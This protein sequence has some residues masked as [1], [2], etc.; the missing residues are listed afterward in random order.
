MW[1]ITYSMIPNFYEKNSSV[2]F[3]LIFMKIYS[4]MQ[5]LPTFY[6][7]KWVSSHYAERRVLIDICYDG[8][9][10]SRPR[11]CHFLGKMLRMAEKCRTH[12]QNF[13]WH[14]VCC[15][16]SLCMFMNNI[17]QY[18]SIL[19]VSLHSTWIVMLQHWE[20]IS[21][22]RDSWHITTFCK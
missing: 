5:T 3:Q 6:S 17:L 22:H 18:I 19:H 10:H 16:C 11:S 9:M 12:F 1:E 21:C 4:F 14:N 2:N 8:R 13:Y 20:H 15:V 7:K